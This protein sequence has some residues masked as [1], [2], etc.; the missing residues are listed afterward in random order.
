MIKGEHRR[1]LVVD[2]EINSSNGNR[3]RALN[4]VTSTKNGPRILEYCKD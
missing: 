3:R 1:A 4:T 2:F